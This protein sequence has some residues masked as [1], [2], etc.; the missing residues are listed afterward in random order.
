VGG[1]LDEAAV[2]FEAGVAAAPPAGH[3]RADGLGYLALAEALAGRL[4]SAVVR[5]DQAADAISSG[6]D[7]LIEHVIPSVDVALAW[8]YCSGV[9]C[10]GRTP[11]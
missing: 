4:S 5:A 8:V 1:R 3:E 9:I 11:G 2:R 10:R 6:G 7:D